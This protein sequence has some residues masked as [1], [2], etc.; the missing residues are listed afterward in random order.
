MLFEIATHG[1]VPFQSLSEDMLKNAISKGNFEFNV[2]SL[3]LSFVFLGHR[4]TLPNEECPDCPEDFSFL[5]G[6]CWDHDP[7]QRP[8][9][10]HVI[11]YIDDTK[12]ADPHLTI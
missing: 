8:T 10:E 2:K 11:T 3:K 9:I 1:F 4:E 5:V 6:Q 12:Q 7:L